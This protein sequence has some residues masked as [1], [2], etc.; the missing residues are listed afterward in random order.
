MLRAG[1][2]HRSSLALGLATL[3]V[4]TLW[5]WTLPQR[6]IPLAHAQGVGLFQRTDCNTLTAPVTGQTCCFDQTTRVL[7]VC[8]GSP[9][10]TTTLSNSGTTGFAGLS[11]VA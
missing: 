9:W 1:R 11:T 5:F 10:A 4:A 2:R 6:E 7:K 3:V 8:T